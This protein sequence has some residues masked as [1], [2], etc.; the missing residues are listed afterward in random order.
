MSLTTKRPSRK[1][2][3]E[4]MVGKVTTEE[5]KWHWI[6]IDIEDVIYKT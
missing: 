1:A 5:E 3:S 4:K 6:N 2:T